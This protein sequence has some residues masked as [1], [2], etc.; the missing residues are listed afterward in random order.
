MSNAQSVASVRQPHIYADITEVIGNTP[1]VRMPRIMATH[2]SQA[3]LLAKLEYFNPAGSIKDRAARSMLAALKNSPQ[4]NSRTHIVEAT[5][6]NSGVA[7]ACL[8]AIY[9]IPLTIVM[10]ENMSLERQKLIKHYGATLITTPAE[11]GTPGAIAYCE[12]LVEENPDAVAIDQF[13]NL[14]NPAAHSRTTA[15]EIWRDTAGTVDVVVAGVGTGGTITGLS[16]TLKKHNP[17]IEIVLAEPASCPLHSEG[18]VGKHLIQG[19]STGHMPAVF[20]R[21]AVDTVVTVADEDAI[22]MAKALARSE[23]M[24]VG[25]SSGTVTVA[26]CELAKQA[27]YR[28]KNIVVIMADGAER[29]YSTCLF[30]D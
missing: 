11:L 17:E 4:F 5:S 3:N 19:I 8:C 21:Q 16:H 14:A 30:E 1:L 28:H 27:Q 20:Q 2:Q 23:G 7:C 22:K 6:G 15:E 29:Y 10:P 24:A 9:G 18:K 26:A 12:K 13:S 25:L